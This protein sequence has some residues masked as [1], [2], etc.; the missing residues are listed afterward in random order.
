MQEVFIA[1][2]AN[3]SNKYKT[4]A[5]DILQ[6]AFLVTAVSP[7]CQVSKVTGLTITVSYWFLWI[8]PGLWLWPWPFIVWDKLQSFQMISLLYVPR[9]MV[10]LTEY[11]ALP[12]HHPQLSPPCSNKPES[13]LKSMLTEQTKARSKYL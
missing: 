6:M 10:R 5:L 2:K 8:L 4:I 7:K 9:T 12:K 3:F 11:P 1:K 13:F